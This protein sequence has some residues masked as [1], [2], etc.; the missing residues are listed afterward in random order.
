MSERAFV[1]RIV[2][3][4]RRRGWFVQRFEDAVSRGIPDIYAAR[5]GRSV[6]IE[7]KYLHSWPKRDT[8]P[9]RIGLRP[10]QVVWIEDAVAAGVDVRIAVRVGRQNELWF[11]GA[12]V[13]WLAAGQPRAAL[14]RAA[15][16]SLY[17]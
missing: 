6:W 16:P 10:E 1:R 12:L 7:A 5:D 2:R 15:G 13:R 8:T 11:R 4:L 9:V 17:I 14:L 3:E